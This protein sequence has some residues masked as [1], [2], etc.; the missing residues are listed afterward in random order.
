MSDDRIQ[1]CI[2]ISKDNIDI[3]GKALEEYW[4]LQYH[5]AHTINEINEARLR[6]SKIKEKKT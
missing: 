6:I 5:G 4:S 3:I 2:S 1:E